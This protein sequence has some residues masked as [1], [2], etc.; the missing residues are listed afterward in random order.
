MRMAFEDFLFF[1]TKASLI[2]SRSLKG[3]VEMSTSLE[4]ASKSAQTLEL[5]TKMT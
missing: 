1:R 5:P 3:V 4:Q 2:G